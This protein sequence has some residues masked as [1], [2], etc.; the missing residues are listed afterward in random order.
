MSGSVPNTL[1]VTVDRELCMGSGTCVSV[2][3]AL[4][5]IGEDGTARPVQSVINPGEQ[6]DR[7]M[8]RCP[9]AAIAATPAT[10]ATP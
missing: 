2:A 10:V 4:F 6:L 3:P 1:R 8:S 7:A 9:T 5:G